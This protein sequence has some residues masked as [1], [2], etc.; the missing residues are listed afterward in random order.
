[1]VPFASLTAMVT[2]V[3]AHD[4]ILAGAEGERA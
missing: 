1:M 4:G 2:N 3:V